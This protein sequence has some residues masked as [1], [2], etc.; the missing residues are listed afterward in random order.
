LAELE[1]NFQIQPKL[2]LTLQKVLEDD[3][4][5]QNKAKA[6][7]LIQQLKAIG[8]DLRLLMVEKVEF[9]L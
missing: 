2:R 6:C 3:F 9:Q 8:E 4:N 5:F 7:A 1:F